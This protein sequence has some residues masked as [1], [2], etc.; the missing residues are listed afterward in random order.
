MADIKGRDCCRGCPYY[1]E[2]WTDYGP[3]NDCR[4]L[5]QEYF[6][7]D[8][9]EFVND[10]GSVNKKELKKFSKEMYE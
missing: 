9:C 7:P 4:L 8:G 2:G 10:D 5:G 1:S 6:T 3:Y